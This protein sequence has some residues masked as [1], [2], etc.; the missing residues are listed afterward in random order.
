MS[1]DDSCQKTKCEV[2]REVRECRKK[3]DPSITDLTER[4][5]PIWICADCYNTIFLE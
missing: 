5:E 3:T 4:F 2:C 1:N